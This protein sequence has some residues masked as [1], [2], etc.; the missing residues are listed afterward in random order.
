MLRIWNKQEAAINIIYIHWLSTVIAA[1]CILYSGHVN[2][3]SLLISRQAY[4]SFYI[5]NTY[6]ISPNKHHGAFFY[7]FIFLHEMKWIFVEKRTLSNGHRKIPLIKH[8][9]VNNPARFESTFQQGIWGTLHINSIILGTFLD[10]TSPSWR[11]WI[12]STS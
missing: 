9:L 2:E 11:T 7:L 12:E 4:K 6:H 10:K 1:T 5:Y 3:Y 8:I